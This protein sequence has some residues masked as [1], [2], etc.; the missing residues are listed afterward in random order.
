M[1]TT[2]ITTAP[3]TYALVLAGRK[4]NTVR[5]GSLGTLELKPGV[6]IYIGSAFGPGGLAARIRHHTEIA[7]RPHWHSDYLRAACD[8]IEVWITTQGG[9]HEHSWAR[10][11]AR[12]PG[13]QVPMPGFGSSDC[14]CQT[15]LFWFQHAPSIR[16]FR[17]FV[18]TMVNVRR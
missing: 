17:R 9:R 1:A 10:A 8:L 2:A 5:I 11:V 3:G 15:H 4:T 18:Q 12:L 6:Y 13:S 16:T 14:N 7:V